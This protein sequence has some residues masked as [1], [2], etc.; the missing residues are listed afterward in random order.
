[1]ALPIEH[2]MTGEPLFFFRYS[3]GTEQWKLS[4]SLIDFLLW[5]YFS[6]GLYVLDVTFTLSNTY[7]AFNNSS[8]NT[9][10]IPV[11]NT[12]KMIDWVNCRYRSKIELELIG[13]SKVGHLV[14]FAFQDWLSTMVQVWTTDKNSFVFQKNSGN[15]F[16]AVNVHLHHVNCLYPRDLSTWTLHLCMVDNQRVAV[17]T[18][19]SLLWRSLNLYFMQN[20]TRG[21]RYQDMMSSWSSAG[22]TSRR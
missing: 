3:E 9:L 8:L 12:F 7:C 1:M 22:S 10:W 13:A 5:G 15:Y 4:Q 19:I 16:S 17:L 18:L 2:D 14:F 20:Y 6:N 21:Y 11:I